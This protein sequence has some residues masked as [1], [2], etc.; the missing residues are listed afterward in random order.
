LL[1]GAT[2]VVLRN[3]LTH[4]YEMLPVCIVNSWTDP[5]TVPSGRSSVFEANRYLTIRP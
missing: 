4:L 1:C 3:S 5:Y 2:P